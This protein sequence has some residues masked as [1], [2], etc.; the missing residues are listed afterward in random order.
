MFDAKY[1]FKLDDETQVET[2]GG[3]VTA[4]NLVGRDY[5]EGDYFDDEYVPTFIVEGQTGG[6]TVRQEDVTAIIDLT[7]EPGN[8]LQSMYCKHCETEF[9]PEEAGRDWDATM[10]Q[11]Y[12]TCPDCGIHT[13]TVR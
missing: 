11:L 2:I 9:T 13:H 1:L 10:D 3:D 12:Y 7:Q 6:F 5:S 8:K 4:T